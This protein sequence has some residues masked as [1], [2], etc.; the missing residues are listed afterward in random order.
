MYQYYCLKY[1]DKLL[2]HKTF[3]NKINDKYYN[4]QINWVLKD[5][6]KFC[7]A[8]NVFIHEFDE[9]IFTFK[10][11][12]KT[13]FLAIRFTYNWKESLLLKNNLIFNEDKQ[14]FYPLNRI[15]FWALPIFING[16]VIGYIGIENPRINYEDNEKEIK[17]FQYEVTSYYLDKRVHA[18][19][20]YAKFDTNLNVIKSDCNF[21][22]L[23]SNNLLSKV[24]C[25]ELKT[26][27]HFICNYLNINHEIINC[28]IYVRYVE[29]L[30]EVHCL[31]IS[32]FK[33]NLK[34]FTNNQ[35]II[36]LRMNNFAA[37][38]N[39]NQEFKITNVN[40]GFY[41]IIKYN[42]AD[43]QAKFNNDLLALIN[44]N[45]Q[46]HFL[47]CVEEAYAEKKIKHCMFYLSDRF[48]MNIKVFALINPYDS[49]MVMVVT[50]Q[51]DIDNISRYELTLGYISRMLI[52]DKIKLM[53]ANKN[54]VDFFDI[55]YDSLDNYLFPPVYH[56]DVRLVGITLNKMRS[57]LPVSIDIR[58][59]RKMGDY[60]WMNIEG[61]CIGVIDKN[62]VYNLLFV[63][64]TSQRILEADLQAKHIKFMMATND[65]HANIFEYDISND[66]Y[67]GKL[68]FS[69]NLSYADDSVI[70]NN[71][72]QNLDNK[73]K[74]TE[75]Q[76]WCKF[77][78]GEVQ[79][80]FEFT[81][82][83][84]DKPLYYRVIG[85]YLYEGK[86]PVKI[87]GKF[88]DC[89]EKRQKEQEVIEKLKY[90]NPT[91][92]F[93]K[94]HGEYVIREIMA[95]SDKVSHLLI[96]NLDSI[97]KIN[98]NYGPMF[99]NMLIK[100]FSQ[101]LKKQLNEEDIVY[102]LNFNQFVVC[103]YDKD[104]NYATEF[105]N[106]ICYLV[107]DIYLGGDE[108]IKLSCNI[109]IT[110]L[111]NKISLDESLRQ[112]GY[113]ISKIKNTGIQIYAYNDT[114]IVYFEGEDV[115]KEAA[116]NMIT[117]DNLIIFALDIL[118][119]TQNIYAAL[120]IL[121]TKVGQQF[122]LK[123]IYIVDID[124]NELKGTI[125]HWWQ[126][127]QRKLE[128]PEE[129][130]FHQ[131]T[132][133]YFLE[134][135]KTNDMLD[136]NCSLYRDFFILNN[137][138]EEV[139][140]KI[141]FSV[142]NY[143]MH[144][145][146]GSIFYVP[147][148]DNFVLKKTD[149]F[150]LY[151]L[152]KIIFTYIRKFVVE[153]INKEQNF[154]LSKISHEI[155][156]PLNSIMLMTKLARNSN[157]KFSNY[158]NKVDASTKYLLSL[159]NN[160]L[161]FSRIE[162]GKLKLCIEDANLNEVLDNIEALMLVQAEEKMLNLK[163][164]KHY[165]YQF[166]QCDVLRL[167]QILINL[168]GNAIKFTPEDGNVTVVIEDLIDD[169]NSITIKFSVC[170]SG[171]GISKE[172]QERIFLPFEQEHIQTSKNYGGS[173]LGLTISYNLVKLMGGMLKVESEVGKGSVFS[174]AIPFSKSKARNSNFTN[175]YLDYTK[176][177]G[178]RVLLVEDNELN[179]DITK[180]ILENIG[181]VVDVAYD[182]ATAIN[183]YNASEINYYQAIFMDIRMPG[184][185]GFNATQ[186]I[187]KTDRDDSLTIPI[188]AM[189]A[190][191]F[192]ED[193]I[194]ARSYGMNSYLTKPIDVIKLYDELNKIIK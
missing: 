115:I 175:Q 100:D 191:A 141:I 60:I 101:L 29:N 168:I 34:I 144:K 7:K 79:N 139:V 158:L 167:T 165:K 124:V 106:Q 87:I 70:V 193:A 90:D 183:K 86:K 110:Y 91:G 136:V 126:S 107:Q 15:N 84:G 44:Q 109:G 179:A 48:H 73:A 153:N 16:K 147:N 142:A 46:K 98:E 154:F 13:Y 30:Y 76:K 26:D 120:N 155:R 192:D 96:I 162:S 89:T 125:K 128:I 3:I 14:H 93:N 69:Q 174:F 103:L 88:I 105:S 27:N 182:G 187:R 194:E 52:G 81:F 176:F 43:L 28:Y 11:S 80:S 55:D 6:I 164:I 21:Y 160:I 171:I 99:G 1:H 59:R 133:M 53:F 68:Y 151:K 135:Y 67:S 82:M 18:L 39:F 104:L 114:D 19:Y 163:F 71:Y 122:N 8:D 75:Y 23:I 10:K 64:I 150:I 188:I 24:F 161:D 121:A 108:A 37:V 134:K 31:D 102:R 35:E 132:L 54:F 32:E 22:K 56:E 157:D 119:K 156:T 190:N 159:V 74:Y 130:H 72:L 45:D 40:Q 172:N 145:Y 131:N 166:I 61:K 50:E 9:L 149:K 4:P 36:K 117:E 66:I 65:N 41:N 146:V 62:P 63:D 33:D 5:T 78:R 123:S 184:L 180:I 116:I 177:H 94:T 143:D 148:E 189:S 113:L 186:I 42:D 170:D 118:E 20:S 57:K 85:T 38:I 152:S 2:K 95:K 169:I 83:K 92:L 77:L 12:L 58:V 111:D 173:G 51:V 127:N 181:L 17:K 129:L 25:D 178:K 49:S 47:E 138:N 97:S 137:I 112:A 140:N 185:D